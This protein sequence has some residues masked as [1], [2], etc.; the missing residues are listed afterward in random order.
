M[1]THSNFLLLGGAV[2]PLCCL[3]GSWNSNTLATWCEELTHWKR[4]WCWERLKVGGEGDNRGWDG[5]MASST[6]WTWVWVISG[7]WWWTGKPGVLPSMGSQ[8][9]GHTEWLNR[10]EPTPIF[11]PG[12]FHGQMSLGE[13]QSIGLHRI[14]H[15]ATNTFTWSEI[16]SL[17]KHSEKSRVNYVWISRGSAKNLKRMSSG[18]DQHWLVCGPA[19]QQW[20]GQWTSSVDNL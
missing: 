14:G 16:S 7:S 11:L 8:R 19:R 13:L 9:V 17:Y 1:A 3:T 10:T 18:R 6:W 2:F 15:S 20:Y 5:W 4:P 12:K